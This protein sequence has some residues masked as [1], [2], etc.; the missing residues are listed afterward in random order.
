[1]VIAFSGKCPCY[2]IK[3]GDGGGESFTRRGVFARGNSAM[4]ELQKRLSNYSTL[5]DQ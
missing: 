5:F 4:S 1:M 3:S 2:S